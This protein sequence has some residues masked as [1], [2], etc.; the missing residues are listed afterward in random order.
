MLTT[1]TIAAFA[2]ALLTQQPT[3]SPSPKIGEPAPTFVA[4]GADGK[5][6]DLASYK[7]KFVVLEWTNK[8][9][10]FVKKHYG[11][12]NMQQTQAKAKE[13]GAVW[14][15]VCSSAPGKQGYLDAAGFTNN[16]TKVGSKAVTV[17]MDPEGKL[18]HMYAAKTTPQIAIIDPSGKLIYNG[19]VDDKPSP[20]PEDIAGAKNYVLA[21]LEEAIAGKS[22]TVATS[23]PYGCSVKY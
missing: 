18:G 15:S 7:G 10:P 1:I 20:N 17:F 16:L 12:N 13:L 8:D 22:V 14:F 9:C 19:A 5:T 2:T 11:S 21:A 4:N 23:R 6:Y 3:A